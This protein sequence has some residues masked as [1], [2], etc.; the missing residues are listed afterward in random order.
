MINFGIANKIDMVTNQDI[1]HIVIV[2]PPYST[3]LN[4]AGPLE[5]F[6]KTIEKSETVPSKTDFKYQTHVISIEESTTVT[7]SSGLSII[8]ESCYKD[9]SYPIDTLI[10]S[11]RS[12]LPDYEFDI[13]FINWLKEQY[14]L[15]RRICSICSGAFLLAEAG[16]L[17]GK[18]ATAHWSRCDKL[19]EEYPKTKVEIS[20]IY[21]KDGKVYT[22]AGITS[23]MDLAI[24]LVEEDFGQPFAL[25]IARWMVLS[26]RRQGNQVQYSTFLDCQSIE[27]PIIRKICQWIV[28]HLSEDLTVEALA[29]N[30]AMS[31]RNFARVFVRELKT[32]PAKYI[33][34][35][36][37]DYACQYLIDTEMSPDKIAEECGLKNAENLRR[38]FLNILEVTP[39]QYKKSFQTSLS[40]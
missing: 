25:H 11:G 35:L 10:I 39:T 28:Q 32:T 19:Q 21:V 8:T 29:E 7:T 6:S 40:N 26:L 1:R 13:A 36:R 12:N 5:I 38:L 23:G 34:R 14:Q 17:D 4:T 15:V 2:A 27:N 22:S 16:I 18:R 24:A 31:P 3:L 30:V 33:N 37:L 9:I 20:R